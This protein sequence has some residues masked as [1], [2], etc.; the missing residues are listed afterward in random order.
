MIIVDFV[1]RSGCIG[2]LDVDIQ[3][4][5]EIQNALFLSCY[6]LTWPAHLRGCPF[7]RN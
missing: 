5:R 1:S 6:L 7:D 2:E 3:I 4:C